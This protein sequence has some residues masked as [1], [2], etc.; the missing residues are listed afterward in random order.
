VQALNTYLRPLDY[1]FSVNPFLWCPQLAVMKAQLLQSI[2]EKVAEV[3]LL[4]Y[5]L[6]HSTL[7]PAILQIGG[8]KLVD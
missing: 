5:L 2:A 7:P 4:V 3:V 1:P 8:L 6:V